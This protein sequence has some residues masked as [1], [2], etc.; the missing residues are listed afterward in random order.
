MQARSFYFYFTGRIGGTRGDLD[1]D[2]TGLLFDMSAEDSFTPARSRCRKWSLM[3]GIYLEDVTIPSS[4]QSSC[5]IFS[6]SGF[7]DTLATHGFSM[8]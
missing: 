2:L 8:R 6:K 3:V 4:L 7:D 1:E 5:D